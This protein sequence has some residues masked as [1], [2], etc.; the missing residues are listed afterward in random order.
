[1]YMGP[2]LSGTLLLSS[3]AVFRIDA[4][5]LVHAVGEVGG[6]LPYS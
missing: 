6:A 2:A 5:G 3:V 1:M 4:D